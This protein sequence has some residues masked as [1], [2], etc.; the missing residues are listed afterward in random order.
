M[1]QATDAF[2]IEKGVPLVGG[3]REARAARYPFKQMEVGDSFFAPVSSYDPRDGRYE[4]ARHQNTIWHCAKYA[5][6]KVATRWQGDG[7]RVWRTA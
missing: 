2:A 7:F 5:G 3:A 4:R 6:V 1:A